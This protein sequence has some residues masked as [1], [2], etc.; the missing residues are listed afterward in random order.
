MT[1]ETDTLKRAE[2]DGCDCP[3]WTIRCVHRDGDVLVLTDGAASNAVPCPVCRPAKM[4]FS[5]ALIRGGWEL[6]LCG[7]HQCFRT[8]QAE[9]LM[10][11]F[12]YDAALA[13]F[14]EIEARLHE[15]E[16]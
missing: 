16:P 14:H 8:A 7:Q 2:R 3:P 4:P 12:D 11:I 9:G 10:R 6:C 13:A 1:T 5:V 15:R